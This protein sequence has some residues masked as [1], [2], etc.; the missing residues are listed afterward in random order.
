[1]DCGFERTAVPP[2]PAKHEG[3]LTGLSCAGKLEVGRLVGR[4]ERTIRAWLRDVDGFRE[5]ARAG[6][7]VPGEPTAEETLRLALHATGKDGGPDWSIRV[8]A[9]RVLFKAQPKPEEAAGDRTFVQVVI[10]PDGTIV[11]EAGV[12]EREPDPDADPQPVAAS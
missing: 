10:Q 4:S 3:P 9:A 11:D 1:M 12:V 7:A 5:A 2:L 6:Q 8:Q